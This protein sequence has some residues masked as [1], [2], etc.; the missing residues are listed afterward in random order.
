MCQ[1]KISGYQGGRAGRIPLFERRLVWAG[2][3]LGAT[4]VVEDHSPFLATLL[5]GR[6]DGPPLPEHTFIMHLVEQGGWIGVRC[7]CAVE[8]ECS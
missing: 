5:V 8:S 3:W 1:Q 6:Q 4:R 7:C 2:A